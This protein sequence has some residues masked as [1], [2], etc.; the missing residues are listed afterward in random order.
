MIFNC[1][2]Q[3]GWQ[4]DHCQTMI[5]YCP[6]ESCQN[7]AVCR[8]LLMNFSC[9]CLGDSY[10]GRYCEITAPKIIIY[11]MLS[12]SFAYIAIIAMVSVATFVVI[13]D[14]LKYCCGIDPT[15]EELKRYRREKQAKKHKPII[16]RFVYV[17]AP[18]DLD[19]Q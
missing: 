15:H 5:N 14:I 10:S 17:N 16:Q 13:M 18:S 11:K 1:T 12:K 4:G 8:P 2:C 9:E 6:N 3:D 7:N 19:Y